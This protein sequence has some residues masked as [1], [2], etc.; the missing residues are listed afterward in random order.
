[1]IYIE[2]IKSLL[3]VLF[4]IEIFHLQTCYNKLCQIYESRII[5]V[6]DSHEEADFIWIDRGSFL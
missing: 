2:V 3:K 6:D 1:M 4:C 5:G